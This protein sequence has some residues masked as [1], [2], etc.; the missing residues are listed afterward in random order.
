MRVIKNMSAEVPDTNGFY[1]RLD[2]L[3]DETS[4]DN[5]YNGYNSIHDNFT[6]GDRQVVLNIW[7]P[8]EFAQL[9]DHFNNN[10]LEYNEQATEVYGVCPFT[11]KW[12]NEVDKDR[13]YK[14]IFYP[15]NKKD[16]PL[17]GTKKYDICYFGGI[18]SQLHLDGLTTM[19]KYNYRYMSMTHGI[20]QRTQ[21]CLLYATDLNLSHSHKIERVG[22]CK[23]SLCY[24][25]VP[26]EAQHLSAIRTYPNWND[27][28]AFADV[29][30]LGYF[31]Q[32]KSRMHEAAM[33][34]T[35]NLVY[36]DPWGITEDY[37]TPEEE[38]VYFD[39][40]DNLQEKIDEILNN[41]DSYE[42]IVEGA[43]NKAL[44]YTTENMIQI[45]NKG[46]VWN[47]HNVDLVNQ[48]D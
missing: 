26:A 48:T 42:G 29:H 3:S 23:I 5:L 11:I 10:A 6:E 24:N 25:V 12:L 14:Y 38:F 9:K 1:F 16:L 30:S 40:S 35:L 8:T 33:A 32:F 15:I 21:Y 36:R 45:I 47:P 7:M 28:K 27:N 18:H 39:S 4:R 43:Y 41:W 31:P 19:F 46:E 20:N 17:E 22:E 37:Y 2:E 13:E 34:K 44:N